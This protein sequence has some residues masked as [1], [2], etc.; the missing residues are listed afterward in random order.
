MLKRIIKRI[1]I[2]LY[3]LRKINYYNL[4]NLIDSN[5]DDVVLLFPSF[6]KNKYNYFFSPAIINDVALLVATIQKQKKFRLL[7]GHKKVLRLRNK[8]ITHNISSLFT[9][10]EGNDYVRSLHNFQQKLIENGNRVIPAQ[11]DTRL[12]ENKIYMHK[13][14]KDLNISHPETIV[15]DSQS[16][17]PENPI[18]KFPLLFKPAH[19]SG[20]TGI[21]K[22]DNLEQYT[23]VIN[24][25]K[26]SEYM[27]QEWIDMRSDLRLIF[28]GDELDL[29]YWRINESP[30]WKPTSTGHGSSV[31]FVSLPK[32]WMNYIYEE[33]KKLDI[34]T[35]AFDIT[36]RNDDLNSKPLI[37]EVSPSYMP[38]PAPVGKY[39]DLPYGKYKSALWGKEAYYKQ[40]IDL[41]F[42]QKLKL[43]EAYDKESRK[44]GY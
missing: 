2:Y 9:F 42:N 13:L 28:I 33:Y 15:V 18:M 19:S 35:G 27:I 4:W 39:I 7:F 10:Y 22:I 8:K 32:K 31:D 26:Y 14:F 17:P 20:S 1:L 41:V 11:K 6:P 29:H 40:Y 16:K 21:L 23:D 44:N 37:L 30:E 38:N 5:S 34:Y 12:W 25:T 24:N 36:W 3:L 43:L